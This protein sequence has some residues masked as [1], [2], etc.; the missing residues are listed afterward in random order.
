M[1][2][3]IATYQVT[4]GSVDEIVAV[5][6]DGLLSIFQDS[7]GFIRYGV[8]DPGDG[9]VVSLSLW[10][11]R[12]EAERAVGDAAGFVRDHLSDKVSLVTNAVGNLAFFEGGRSSL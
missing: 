4:G 8:V 10:G 12:P 6:Q 3:R 7:P 9:T 1:H 11:S 5:V 2:A